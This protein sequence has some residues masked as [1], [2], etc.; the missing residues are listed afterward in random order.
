[1]AI[2]NWSGREWLTNE[3]WGFIHPEKSDWWYDATAVEVDYYDQIHLKTHI[4]GRWFPELSKISEVGAGLITSVENFT[5]GTFT[6]EAKLPQGKNLWPAFW[7]SPRYVWPPEIDIMEAYSNKRGSYFKFGKS[8]WHVETNIWTGKVNNIPKN[9]GSER[10]FYTFKNPSK[11]FFKYSVT[12]TP[13]LV[14]IFYN[15]KSVRK[16]TDKTALDALN[17]V[18]SLH[19]IINNGITKLGEK[20]TTDF[21]VRYFDYK[22]L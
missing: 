6:I 4:H 20:N 7:I 16:C 14:E 21:V 8:F 9:L 10:P 2:I 15:G 18:D 12:W 17:K 13:D 19:V 11:H 22:P 3:R 1:M 5:Y